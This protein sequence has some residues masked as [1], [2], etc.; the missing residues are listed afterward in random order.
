MTGGAQLGDVQPLHL[1]HR[2]QRVR[3]LGGRV[4]LAPVRHRGQE[5]RVGLDQ[6]QLGRRDRRRLAQ[7]ARARRTSR[8]PRS[9]SRSR[10]RRTAAPSPRRRRSSGRRHARAA[11]SSAEDVEHVIVRVPVVDH[12]RLA[13]RLAI[14]MCARNHSR[15]TLRRRAVPV[16]VQAGLADRA[17]LRQRGQRRRSRPGPRPGRRDRP[18]RWRSRS[19]GSPPPRRRRRAR[20]RTPPPSGRTPASQPT[21]T[22]RTMPA[23]RAGASTCSTGPASM[24]RWVC[25]SK[26]RPAAAQAAGRA[27]RSGS[28]SA[29]Q[30]FMIPPQVVPPSRS[31][32]S[33]TTAGS[34]LANSGVGGSSG[35]PGLIGADAQVAA[36]VVV[37]GDDRV[38]QAAR[39]RRPRRSAACPT[40]R[41]GR[42]ASRTPAATTAAGTA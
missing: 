26:A 37:A 5:R 13:G 2:A 36:P 16:V 38:R 15:W 42:R 10:R 17:H 41:P 35:V 30:P 4:R 25:A 20:R 6:D 40:T 29:R 11:L 39:P 21:V 12:Q 31:S 22:T 18:A 8:C 19:G 33:S 7:A 34:S 14:S 3:D 28:A 23:A 32:S 24:S 27:E 9:S 1:G